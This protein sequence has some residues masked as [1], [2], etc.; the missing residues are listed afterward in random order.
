MSETFEL[1]LSNF[2]SIGASSMSFSPG[3]TLLV[4]QSNS[5]KSANL[6]ALKALLMNS[7]R[8]KSYIKHGKGVAN[9]EVI[10]NGNDISWSRSNKESS[11]NINGEE[12]DKVGSKTLFDLL[13]VNGFVR[14]DDNNIMNIEGELE[15]PFP[16]DRT[17][18]QLFKL[19]ENIF[20][21]SDSALIIKTFKDDEN[22]YT[23]QK[24]SYEEK[25]VRVTSKLKALEELKAEVDLDAVKVRLQQ[26]KEHSDKYLEMFDDI[27]KLYHGFRISSIEL[28]GVNP[29]DKSTL[30]DYISLR[31]DISFLYN[32]VLAR[33]R[34]FKELPEPLALTN[35][36]DRYMELYEGLVFINRALELNKLDTDI[37]FLTINNTLDSYIELREDLDTIRLGELAEHFSIDEFSEVSNS[38][39]SFLNM[40]EDYKFVLNCYDMCSSSKTRYSE[41]EQRIQVLNEDLGKY[42]VCPLCGHE[43]E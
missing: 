11:Y 8:A 39:E 37:P 2:Q 30:E 29:P 12:Y 16:Y 4:G 42:K 28:D 40:L 23:K 1:K 32:K 38:L 21:V 15:L 34:F 27:S 22:S 36:L 19:F 33:Q 20:C 10:Y 35:S 31:Q 13:P 17:P 24:S 7:P 6:R 43:L 25:L 26:F 3:I 9:V 5:G 14:D 41:L 18:S